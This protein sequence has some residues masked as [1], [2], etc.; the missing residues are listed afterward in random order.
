ML[1]SSVGDGAPGRYGSAICC[2]MSSMDVIESPRASQRALSMADECSHCREELARLTE[3][4]AALRRSA[5]AFGG[6]AERL[7]VALKEER[8]AGR[9]HGTS[10]DGAET[11]TEWNFDPTHL[12]RPTGISG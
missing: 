3:E 9:R 12:R 11:P 2:V 1:W 7:S 8:R 10:R 4:N 5:L 6:L